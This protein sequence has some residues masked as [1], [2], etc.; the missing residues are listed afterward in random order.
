[1]PMEIRPYRA[2]DEVA[3]AEV[4]NV[5][6]GPL[7]AFK[8]ATADEIRRRGGADRLFAVDHGRVIGYAAF[9]LNG[10]I[11][12][13][14]CL[15]DFG[16]ARGPLLDAL[17]AEMARS[18]HA[19][20]WTTYRPD[21]DAVL[22]FFEQHGFARVRAMV[23]YVAEV[24]DLPRVGVPAG[25]ALDRLDTDDVPALIDL[26]R[27]LFAGQSVV[28]LTHALLE[29][30][31][32]PPEALFV[33]RA[34]DGRLRGAGL[35]IADGR[36]ADPTQVN[37]AM[38]CFRL[39][40]FGTETERH[41]RIDGVVSVVFEAAEDGD[42]LLSEAARRL[43]AAG[44]RHAAAQVPSDRPELVAFH[45]QYFRRQGAFPILERRLR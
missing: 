26:G 32:L 5:A 3:Q 44:R 10:R 16:H 22:G 28:G 45:D 37:P 30:P 11:S 29:N 23:N 25:A 41:K 36:Y 39:G 42:A 9:N 34:E 38:P 19:V 4:Y 33:L 6:A 13:P 1:M 31:Y 21:W 8:P 7:P 17:L 2:G 18:G 15:P 43:E 20:A 40:S 27:G 14:W 12:F 24:A 35:A